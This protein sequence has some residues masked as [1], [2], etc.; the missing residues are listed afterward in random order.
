M[1]C[2]GPSF[3]A[4]AKGMGSCLIVGSAYNNNTNAK[5]ERANGVIGDTLRAYAN[6]R[7]DDLSRCSPSRMR[8]PPRR[9]AHALIHRQGAASAS[10]PAAVR[11]ARRQRPGRDTGGRM[12]ELT[13]TV[14]ALLAA[15]QQER[16]AK[17]DA[18]RV[19]TVFKVGDRVLLR[20]KELLGDLVLLRSRKD[21]GAARRRR[22]RRHWQAA[23]AVGRPLHRMAPPP[24]RPAPAPTP[25]HSPSHGGCSAARQ[26]TSTGPDPST[27]GSRPST[28]GSTPR[29]PPAR[30]RTR[31]RRES[32]R[33]S[34]CST[35]RR[36][37]ASR[38]TWS[39]GGATRRRRT[40]GC[41]RRSCCTARRRW[42]STT[43]PPPAA[44]RPAVGSPRQARRWCRPGWTHSRR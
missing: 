1:T 35:A 40:S 31:G 30:F 7:K 3:R 43:Q 13:L 23:A 4:F 16:K 20:T 26:S 15:A 38:A 21:Q 22:R 25:T 28:S 6:G 5:V 27:T 39:G 10:A 12:R 41:G 36:H 8:P 34:C 29:R 42:P 33:W 17:R 18:G 2:S 9:R 24:S 11:P 44:A 37:G 19:D 14:R 32:T